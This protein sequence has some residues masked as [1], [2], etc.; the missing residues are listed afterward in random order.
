MKEEKYFSFI[1][2]SL[3]TLELIKQ[4]LLTKYYG[5]YNFEY[6]PFQLCS[7]PIYLLLFYK[8]L[9]KEVVKTYLGTY[10]LLGGSY[11][12]LDTSGFIYPIKI[13]TIYSYLYHLFLLLLGLYCFKKMS[14]NFLKASLLFLF[15]VLIATLL[16]IT[17]GQTSYINMFFISPLI[18]MNQI[19]FKDLN[20]SN[21]LKIIVYILTCILGAFIFY[22]IKKVHSR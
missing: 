5:Y 6:F 22:L 19:Y 9:N 8:L 1:G 13:L 10:G 17:I 4:I 15:F 21:N 3:F 16:N 20:L 11:V 18:K 7:T 12:W 2:L 14:N